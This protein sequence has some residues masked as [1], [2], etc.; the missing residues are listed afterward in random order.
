MYLNIH[1]HYKSDYMI[2]VREYL[3]FFSHQFI[4]KKRCTQ[5]IMFEKSLCAFGFSQISTHEHTFIRLL[6]LLV[7]IWY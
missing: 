4:N 5:D 6:K 2:Y 7:P 1:L 3:Q